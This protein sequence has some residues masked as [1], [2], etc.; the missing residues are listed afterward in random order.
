MK[1]SVNAPSLRRPKGVLTPAY[2]PMVKIWVDA[3]EVA[4]YRR[5]NPMVEI[6]ECPAGVQGNLSRVRNHILREEFAAGMDAVVIID[7]DLKRIGYFESI[8]RFGYNDRLL[9]VEDWPDFIENYSGMARGIGAYM[10]G[11]NVN[12]DADA[13][14]QYRPFNTTSPVLGPFSVHLKGGD[15]FYDERLPLKEDYDISLQ[16][17][18]KYRAILRLNKYHYE[19]LQSVNAG[20]CAVYR[21]MDREREQLDLLIKKWGSGIVHTDKRRQDGKASSVLDYNP[22]IKAPI[23]GV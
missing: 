18:N 5:E 15:I 7:D 1:F 6:V 21:S 9:R 3:S 20:G 11:M 14:D 23:K 12:N 16:H 22:I 19:C 13:Y 2:Y 8:G 4:E 17:L 10:W